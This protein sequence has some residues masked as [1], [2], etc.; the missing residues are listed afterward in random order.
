MAGA[1]PLLALTRLHL[2][3]LLSSLPSPPDSSSLDEAIRT[4]A[5]VASGLEEVLR[6]GHPVR[7]LARAELGKL[8]AVDEPSAEATT[9]P[10]AVGAEVFPPRGSARL[11]L[12][13]GTLQRA[14]AELS[15]GFGPGGGEVGRDVRETLLNLEKE[16]GVWKEGIK[17]VTEY[18]EPIRR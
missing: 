3:L 17:S 4:A 10:Q 15:I 8:L 11:A 6:E 9:S 18:G 2:S 16:I 7:G 13:Y 14:Y 12:A 5:R 1:H